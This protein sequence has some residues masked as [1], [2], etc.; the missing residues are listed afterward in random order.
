MDRLTGDKGR[1]DVWSE[2][3]GE[4]WKIKCAVNAERRYSLV[5]G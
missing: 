1:G 3:G 5:D 2:V 4:R